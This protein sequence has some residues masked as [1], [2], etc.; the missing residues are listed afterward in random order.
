V[1]PLSAGA[2]AGSLAL[3]VGRA[4]EPAEK[5][6]EVKECLP[7]LC[8]T[9]LDNQVMQG[10]GP[11]DWQLPAAVT[12]AWPS[13]RLPGCPGLVLP[14]GQLPVPRRRRARPGL[15]RSG[16]AGSSRRCGA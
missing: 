10:S 1:G 6:F 3:I 4:Q 13:R 7:A 9:A 14:P 11:E 16:C 5:G 15:A 8:S 2:T 12:L